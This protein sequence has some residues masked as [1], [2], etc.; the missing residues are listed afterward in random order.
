M[1]SNKK[2]KEEKQIEYSKTQRRLFNVIRDKK[3]FAIGTE[4]W[5]EEEIEPKEIEEKLEEEVKKE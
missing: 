5:P 4:P 2:D 1:G 3:G